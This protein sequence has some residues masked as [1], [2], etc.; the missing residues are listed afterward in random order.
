MWE[1][2]GKER[3]QENAL[4]LLSSSSCV[5]NMPTQL[6]C[7]GRAAMEKWTNRRL[8][9]LSLRASLASGVIATEENGEI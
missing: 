9:P 1:E 7:P 4:F 8:Q 2:R 3:Q 5:V 6:L